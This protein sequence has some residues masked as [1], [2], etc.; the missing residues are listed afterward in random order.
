MV[1]KSKPN[2]H[3]ALKVTSQETSNLLTFMTCSTSNFSSLQKA[4]MV[5]TNLVSGRGIWS[6]RGP[7]GVMEK[8][9]ILLSP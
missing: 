4:D 9:N 2:K 8:A 1:I 6:F 7:G 5:R 3:S